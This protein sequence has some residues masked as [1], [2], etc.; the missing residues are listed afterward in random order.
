LPY[1]PHSS[2][3]QLWRNILRYR[4]QNRCSLE[5]YISFVHMRPE[6]VLVFCGSLFSF[7]SIKK[8]AQLANGPVLQVTL[9]GCCLFSANPLS[10]LPQK[11][12]A[13]SLQPRNS[14]CLELTNCLCVYGLGIASYIPSVGLYKAG[15]RVLLFRKIWGKQTWLLFMYEDIF[16]WEL[17]SCGLFR[18]E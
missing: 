10:Q 5:K 6:Y 7:W 14:T 17:R 18:S 15:G 3:M 4:T 2:T 12:L 1:H 9:Q 13:P 8:I 16:R 11:R